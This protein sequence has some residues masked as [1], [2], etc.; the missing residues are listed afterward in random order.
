LSAVN[1]IAWLSRL[2]DVT[3]IQCPLT[4]VMSTAVADLQ[5]RGV[6]MCTCDTWK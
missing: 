4:M 3:T 1:R 5:T 2:P 6:A